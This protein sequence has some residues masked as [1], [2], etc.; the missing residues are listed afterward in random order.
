M[1][2]MSVDETCELLC[3]DVPRAEA[4]R[5]GV[6]TL[7]ELQEDSADGAKATSDPTRLRLALAKAGSGVTS[8]GSANVR[9]R[10]FPTTFASSAAPAWRVRARPGGCTGY[11][12]RG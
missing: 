5:R 8:R 7:D 2:G 6:Q 1:S 11:P 12:R 4:L 3:V 9:T 10:S